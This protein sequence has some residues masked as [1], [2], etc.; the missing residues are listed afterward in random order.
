MPRTDKFEDKAAITGIGMS[1]VGRR[2]MRP[3]LSLTV[4]AIK[5]AVADAGLQMDDIDGLSTW[6]GS[7]NAGGMSE[8]GV[9]C[10]RGCPGGSRPTWHD[11]GGAETFCPAGSIIAAMLAIAAGLA[12]H[13]VCF[14]TD[15]QA[16][17]AAQL[18]EKGG[19]NPFGLG[20]SQERVP[21][22][23]GPYGESSAAITLALR[24]SNH[25]ARYG[26]TRETLGWIALTERANAALNPKAIYRDPMTMDDYLSGPHGLQPSSAST[27]VTC[28]R[29]APSP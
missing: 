26:T 8:G 20:S 1:D 2:L 17:Y 28:R 25:F 21:G 7:L 27:T 14:R 16:T 22:Y 6:P 5:E 29:T 12:R 19:T 3:A 11:N 10:S 13:V 24:A 9:S 15:W 23:S 4:D 18:R